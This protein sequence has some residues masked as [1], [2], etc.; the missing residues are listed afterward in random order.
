MGVWAKGLWGLRSEGGGA[1]ANGGGRGRAGALL[2]TLSRASSL[3]LS[4]GSP[5]FSLLPKDVPN[6]PF[7]GFCSMSCSSI[8]G[9]WVC[10]CGCL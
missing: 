3:S 2:A 4:L 1:G 9:V 5:F 7:V 6:L 8:N 10:V